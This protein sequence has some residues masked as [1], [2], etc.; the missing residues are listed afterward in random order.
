L[1]VAAVVVAWFA[2]SEGFTGFWYAVH[3]AKLA[4]NRSIPDGPAL[5]QRLEDYAT[6]SG[7]QVTER[8]IGSAATEMLKC[9]YGRMAIW[10]GP[11][12]SMAATILRWEG[13]SAVS[14]VES[15]HNPSKCLAAAGWQIGARTDFGI[16]DYCGVSGNVTGWDVSRPGVQMRAFIAV[17]RRFAEDKK[18]K[19]N[20][21][22][23]SNRL[24]PVITGRR[25]APRLIILGYVPAEAS[26]DEAHATV[27]SLLRAALCGKQ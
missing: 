13:S 16:E 20:S 2:L 22:W 14:G 8:D 26:M 18:P 1:I 24:E 17:F 15:M 6:A 21:F 7:A 3:E 19:A 25:D 11:A 9:S 23:N 4:K 5:L 10:N 27:Q 12:G